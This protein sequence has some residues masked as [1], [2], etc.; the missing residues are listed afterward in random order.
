MEHKTTSEGMRVVAQQRSWNSLCW[1][2]KHSLAQKTRVGPLRRERI[3]VYLLGAPG[4]GKTSIWRRS[5]L[6][7]ELGVT[8]Y[9]AGCFYKLLSCLS[10]HA[11]KWKMILD[12]LGLQN[13]GIPN[14]K[15]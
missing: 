6:L 10:L 5:R 13:S 2:D 12:V 4:V 15:A 1:L 3:A 9:V 8:N 14:N 11:P 7:H